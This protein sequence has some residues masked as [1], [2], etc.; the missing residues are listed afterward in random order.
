[1]R[2]YLQNLCI[3]NGSLSQP[4]N[5]Q[6]LHSYLVLLDFDLI[7][8]GLLKMLLIVDDALRGLHRKSGEKHHQC[9]QYKER[10]KEDAQILQIAT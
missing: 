5:V 9:N 7:G 8:E 2:T 1:M 3:H 4:H 6:F 10:T